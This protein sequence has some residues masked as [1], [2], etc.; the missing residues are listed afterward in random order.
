MVASVF[1]GHPVD[2][3][4][5]RKLLTGWKAGREKVMRRMKREEERGEGGRILTGVDMKTEEERGVSRH[6]IFCN[7]HTAR[8]TR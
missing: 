4:L 8:N 3:C 5:S 6:G 7:S 1:W 2:V